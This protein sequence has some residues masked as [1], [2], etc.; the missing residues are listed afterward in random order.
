MSAAAIARR[1]LPR[2]AK[3]AATVQMKASAKPTMSSL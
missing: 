3:Y 1:L 2:R